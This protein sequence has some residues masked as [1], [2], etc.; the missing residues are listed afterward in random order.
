MFNELFVRNVRSL[1]FKIYSIQGKLNSS[2]W[3]I[4]YFVYQKKKE[5][6]L[7]LIKTL[8]NPNVIPTNIA[9]SSTNPLEWN[10]NPDKIYFEQSSASGQIYLKLNP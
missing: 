3:L 6:H 7:K 9:T 8:V 4:S 1:S 5:V 10:E 2:E